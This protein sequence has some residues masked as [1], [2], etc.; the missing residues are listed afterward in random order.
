MN[1]G[2]RRSDL[3]E[4][5]HREILER[6][7]QQLADQVL[8]L[9]EKLEQATEEREEALLKM[10]RLKQELEKQK[11]EASGLRKNQDLLIEER[12]R[13]QAE[14]IEKLR[15]S[16]L[17][18]VL[19]GLRDLLRHTVGE[20]GMTAVDIDLIEQVLVHVV[21]IGLGVLG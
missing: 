1:D 3:D 21:A 9:S 14:Q 6:Q 19:D 5:S 13:W 16:P 8:E 12:G 10:D 2:S 4:R 11:R 17:R 7:R 20:M 15:R 18:K